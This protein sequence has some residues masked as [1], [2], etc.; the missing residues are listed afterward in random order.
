[1][2]RPIAG[3]FIV[4]SLLW[5]IGS[6]E[7]AQN[8]TKERVQATLRQYVLERVPWQPEQ[9]QVSVRPFM[10]P[11]L[12]E[13]QLALRVVKANETIVPGSH[14][15]LLQVS[16]GQEE[17]ARLWVR[18]DIAVFADVVVTSRPFARFETITSG[19]VRLERRELNSA[20][21]RAFTRLDEVVGK[22]AARAIGVNEVL[23]SITIEVPRVVLRGGS[24]TLVYESSG[25]RLET[26]GRA[27]DDGRLGDVIKVKNHSSGKVLDGKILD[28]RTVR[29]NW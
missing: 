14:N 15:F 7:G 23:S 28:G 8:L 9:V 5:T 21:M 22:Q 6:G 29:V 11:Q 3:F 26:P 17:R 4:L 2:Y 25:L 27:L 16:I 20:S 10:P 24:I 1:M 18:A 19:D 12:P 13:G